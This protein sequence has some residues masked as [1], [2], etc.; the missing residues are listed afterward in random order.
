MLGLELVETD[1][2][3]GLTFLSSRPGE[4]NHDLSFTRAPQMA[5]VAYEVDSLATLRAYRRKLLDAGVPIVST[6]NFGWSIG[7]TFTDPEGHRCELYWKTGRAQP[8]RT[9]IDL[10]LPDEE[11]AAAIGGPVAA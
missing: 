3:Y 2:D 8:Q 9:P 7:M 5:H 4:V 11:I 6:M 1:R 10:D